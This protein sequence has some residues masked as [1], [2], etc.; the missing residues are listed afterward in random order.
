[1]YTFTN[2]EA[3]DSSSLKKSVELPMPFQLRLCW[4]RLFQLSF[5]VWLEEERKCSATVVGLD[6]LLITNAIEFLRH[7]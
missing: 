1:M 3:I 5:G 6:L 7:W 2:I 4:K